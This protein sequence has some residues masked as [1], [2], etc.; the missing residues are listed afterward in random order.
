MSHSSEWP[1]VHPCLS[2]T[3]TG[4]PR[5]RLGDA[6]NWE[7]GPKSRCQ[8]CPYIR[9]QMGT[10]L[11]LWMPVG[12]DADNWRLLGISTGQ[13]MPAWTDDNQ[14]PDEPPLCPD[15]L[16]ISPPILGGKGGR[17]E[18]PKWIEIPWN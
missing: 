1:E 14:R 5:G 6:V 4:V 11:P 8:H 18:N 3:G 7:E 13:R 17:E 15:V 12:R 9:G 10:Q 2:E 16:S